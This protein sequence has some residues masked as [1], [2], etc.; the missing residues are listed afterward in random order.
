MAREIKFRVA[1]KFCGDPFLG[2]VLELNLSEGTGTCYIWLHSYGGEQQDFDL[3]CGDKLMQYTGIDGWNKET[4]KDDIEIYDSFIVRRIPNDFKD[5][6]FVGVVKQLEGCWVIDNGKDA[7][8][9]FDELGYNEVIGNI[10]ENPELLGG[11]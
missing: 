11:E 1:T 6:I 2:D 7:I 4:Q 3:N 10:Y 5:N 9:L 8:N